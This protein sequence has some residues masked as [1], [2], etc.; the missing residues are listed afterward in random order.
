MEWWNEEQKENVR[1]KK[2]KQ[3]QQQLE[4]KNAIPNK[5]WR[6]VQHKITRSNELGDGV[7]VVV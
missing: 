7:V 6:N 1:Q 2:R 4:K 5:W 3:Q